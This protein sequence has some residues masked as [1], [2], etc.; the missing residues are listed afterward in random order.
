MASTA[1]RRIGRQANH[2]KVI[3]RYLRGG[4][5]LVKAIAFAVH[6]QDVDMMGQP[7]QQ[8]TGEAFGAEGFAL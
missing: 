1:P 7:V 4:T 6:F 5:A 8:C 3:L 2:V